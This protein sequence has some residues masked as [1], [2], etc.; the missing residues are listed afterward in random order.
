[1]LNRLTD[2]GLW[3]LP[4]CNHISRKMS[5]WGT[6]ALLTVSSLRELVLNPPPCGSILYTFPLFRSFGVGQ[7][8]HQGLADAG[9]DISR[10]K[11]SDSQLKIE[12]LD[13]IVSS[14]RGCRRALGAPKCIRNI[15]LKVTAKSVPAET[16]LCCIRFHGSATGSRSWLSS[17]VVIW[18]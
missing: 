9:R 7:R 11:S 4:V 17:S 2:G 14:P 10:G 18:L 6:S 16:T 1:M 12:T 15:H 8:C 3:F 13:Q 5:S